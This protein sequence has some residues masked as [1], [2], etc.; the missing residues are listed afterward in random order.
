VLQP[1]QGQVGGEF[2]A[3]VEHRLPHPGQIPEP[4][5]LVVEQVPRRRAPQPTRYP[6]SCR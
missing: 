4:G 3:A 2:A 6:R 5:E 1:R